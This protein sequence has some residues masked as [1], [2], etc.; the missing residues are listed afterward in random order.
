MALDFIDNGTGF[1]IAGDSYFDWSEDAHR[2]EALR[3]VPALAASRGVNVSEDYSFVNS[4]DLIAELQKR[5]YRLVAADQ[6]FSRKRDPRGQEHVMR[7]RNENCLG[8][9]P[10]LLDSFP[11]IVI[12]NSHNGR[13]A[14]SA[15]M[16]LFRMICSNGMVA[17][18]EELGFHRMR[19]FGKSNTQ[20]AVVDVLGEMS[21]KASVMQNRIEMLD[22]IMLNPHEQNSLAREVAKARGVPS[23]VEPHMVLE[24]RRAMDARSEDGTRSLWVTFNVLQENLTK[25]QISYQPED[26]RA[27]SI[28][29]LSSAVR[30]VTANGAMWEVLS[31]F[32]ERFR[33]PEETELR[34]FDQLISATSYEELESITEAEKVLLTSEQKKKLS[35]RK[36][37]LKRQRERASA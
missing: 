37:Y 19:H 29:P 15:Y 21:R 28:R 33:Q 36:S 14:L 34:T 24:S 4:G 7:F 26:G 32:A 3:R 18:D 25:Q 22:G 30:D 8:T 12:L 35:S 20:A 6:Q 1:R 13:R 17:M 31:T 16:G 5:G 27:R 2:N 10:T 9:S 11:E 23:W